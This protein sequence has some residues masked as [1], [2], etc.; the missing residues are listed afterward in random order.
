[1]RFKNYVKI[2][3]F[4]EGKIYSEDGKVILDKGANFKG[5]IKA[6]YFNNYGSVYGRIYSKQ[7]VSLEKGSRLIGNIKTKVL[8]IKKGAS[9]EGKSFLISE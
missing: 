8:E 2:N 6:K 1:M 3:C 9:F 5:D 4:F 7:E